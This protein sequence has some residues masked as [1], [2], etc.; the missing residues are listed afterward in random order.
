MYLK[1]ITS[2]MEDSN[3][4]KMKRTRLLDFVLIVEALVL[5][6]LQ[7]LL[8]IRIPKEDGVRI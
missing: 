8:Q 1:I 6:K 5:Q 3:F 2:S 7:Q 4:S